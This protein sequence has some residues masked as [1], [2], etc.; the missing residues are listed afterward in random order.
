MTTCDRCK[1]EMDEAQEIGEWLGAPA[2]INDAI[3]AAMYRRNVRKTRRPH[4]RAVVEEAIAIL[5]ERVR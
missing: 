4:V 3:E 2:A 5:R 1:L